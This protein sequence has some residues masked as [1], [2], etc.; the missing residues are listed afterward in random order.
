MPLEAWQ[1]DLFEVLDIEAGRTLLLGV[2]RLV[3]PDSWK[4]ESPVT[5]LRLDLHIY[6]RLGKGCVVR[7]CH[8][9]QWKLWVVFGSARGPGIV[10]V[11][12]LTVGCGA[13]RRSCP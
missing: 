3:G 1:G 6:H 5:G 9:R 11:L 4:D 2:S 13:V 10:A 7:H 12:W 8:Q